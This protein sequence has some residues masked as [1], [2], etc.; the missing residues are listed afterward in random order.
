M[1]WNRP[2]VVF[3]AL[4]A[5]L[6]ASCASPAEN[7][8]AD[9][10]QAAT[11]DPIPDASPTGAPSPILRTSE[12]QRE[13]SQADLAR[14]IGLVQRS[15]P[16]PPSVAL[17]GAQ[18][19]TLA[20][21]SLS[22]L[23]G[24]S[25]SCQITSGP[26]GTRETIYVDSTVGLLQ[27][28][29]GDGTLRR[30]GELVIST[31]R[32]QLIQTGDGQQQLLDTDTHKTHSLGTPFE[33]KFNFFE[34]GGD[35]VAIWGQ[36]AVLVN[37]TIGL[38][39]VLGENERLAGLTAVSASGRLLARAD[40]S[41]GDLQVVVDNLENGTQSVW[42]RSLQSSALWIGE[43]LLVS[44]Q[45]LGSVVVVEGEG[46][47][48]TIP[49]EGQGLITEVL[50][51]P[52]GST[53]LIR[54]SEGQWFSLDLATAQLTARPEL[55]G[56][57]HSIFISSDG[58]AL[59]DNDFIERREDPGTY[60][61]VAAS[62]DVDFVVEI[63][64]APDLLTVMDAGSGLI[65]LTYFESGV[66]GRSARI[67]ELESGTSRPIPMYRSGSVYLSPDSQ[68]LAFT[69][70]SPTSVADE[71]GHLTTAFAV[72]GLGIAEPLWTSNGRFLGWI[73][74]KDRR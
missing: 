32:F 50:P 28:D 58:H 62:Y 43:R 16:G 57:H 12:L 5:P 9:P 14:G 13:W 63:P 4:A 2:L 59:L 69:S 66:T 40:L 8:R 42:Y 24:C 17:I 44:G 56:L 27:L 41:E 7:S 35:W 15:L 52:D 3:I 47:F 67:L 31:G 39:I 60:R 11:A 23:P 61:L 38:E 19:E 74:L 49:L 26:L 68:V 25:E 10:V 54:L 65:I 29:I 53:A 46:E 55:F 34:T 20:E 36:R 22:L 1:R 64:V 6:I 37:P 73:D 18:G 70:R 45:T 72:D 48:E 30:M 51:A 33:G 21:F 71:T